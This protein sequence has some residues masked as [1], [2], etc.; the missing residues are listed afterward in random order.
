MKKYYIGL[1]VIG[2]V[3]AGLAVYVLSLGQQSKQ[4]KKTYEKAQDTA[5][6]LND[7]IREERTIPGSLAEA[8]VSDVPE[9]ITY[10]KLSEKEYKFCVTYKANKGYGGADITSVATGALY[11]SMYRGDYEY[12]K[13]ES[14]YKPSTLYLSPYYT[15]GES[16]QTIQPYISSSQSNRQNSNQLDEL[17]EQEAMDSYQQVYDTYCGATADESYQSYCEILE[18]RLNSQTN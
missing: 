7:F 11:G 1:L 18:Q 5:E 12:S 13:S 6:K 16:C 3:T 14:E 10:E 17:D 4:D 9:S 15:K 8:G 2:L